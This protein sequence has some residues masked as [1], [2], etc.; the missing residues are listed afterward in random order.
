MTNIRTTLLQKNPFR[1]LIRREKAQR[2]ILLLLISFAITVIMTRLFLTLT[3][4][5]QIGNGELHISHLLWGGLL[6]FIT[7]LLLLALENLWVYRVSAV[8]GG[9]GVGLFIDEIGKFITRNNDYFFPWAIPLIYAFGLILALIYLEFRRT[10]STDERAEMY[11]ALELFKYVLDNDLTPAEFDD[12]N[13]RLKIVA[14]Q[15]KVPDITRLATVLLDYLSSGQIK[16]TNDL[17]GPLGRLE[18]KMQRFLRESIGMARLRLT[19]IVGLLLV[20]LTSLFEPFTVFLAPL[21]P[22]LLR[23]ILGGLMHAG[24]IQGVHSLD[25]FLLRLVLEGSIGIILIIA[26]ILFIARHNRRGSEI[27][28]IGLLLALTIVNLL[29][30]YFDQFGNIFLTVIEIGL[31]II[32]LQ[33]RYDLKRQL[34]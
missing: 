26:S 25:W 9:I 27:G 8:M 23:N 29:A 12:L 7:V 14:S 19:L 30:F 21:D 28:Y 2:F 31:L 4:F 15:N 17:P 33:Y 24:Q 11:R 10:E 13:G 22:I 32:L 6:L 34:A 3:G 20:G 18:G 1:R 16:L 5:P